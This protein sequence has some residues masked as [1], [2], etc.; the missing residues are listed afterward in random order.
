MKMTAT[1]SVIGRIYLGALCVLLLILANVTISVAWDQGDS[2]ENVID[3]KERPRDNRLVQFQSEYDEALNL[4]WIGD[5][6]DK[7]RESQK[8][9]PVL[10]AEILP[11]GT[12]DVNTFDFHLFY[13]SRVTDNVRAIPRKVTI[14]PVL[15]LYVF[16]P[17]GV[18]PN[19]DKSEGALTAETKP[20]DRVEPVK[21]H[22]PVSKAP[23]ANSGV[24]E[25]RNRDHKVN[26]GLHPA[27]TLLHSSTQV[28]VRLQNSLLSTNVCLQCVFGWDENEV[29]FCYLC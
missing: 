1:F 6:L 15:D 7:S 2:T 28:C 25:S 3:G 22:A 5:K 17:D 19:S 13:A 4:Y 12:V 21:P 26:N 18:R 16:H 11:R 20:I 14:S 23:I 27:V 9:T 24:Y 29:T 10:I 8:V